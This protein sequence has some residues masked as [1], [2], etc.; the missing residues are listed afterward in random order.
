MDLPINWFGLVW[1]G[2]SPQLTRSHSS[3]D[4][5][6]DVWKVDRLI[7]FDSIWFDLIRFH[8]IPNTCS[9]I[10]QDALVVMG[11]D[12]MTDRRHKRLDCQRSMLQKNILSPMSQHKEVSIVLLKNLKGVESSEGKF[13]T[14]GHALS[15]EESTRNHANGS[16]FW[17]KTSFLTLI[18]RKMFCTRAPVLLT[19]HV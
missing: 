11:K 2:L 13:M 8:S 9:L 1:F 12:A 6:D 15:S 5:D 3:N 16:R 17:T 7:R 10:W 14:G 18:K 4:D 19:I